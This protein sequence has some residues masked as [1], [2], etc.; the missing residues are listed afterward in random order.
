MKVTY[1]YES[2]RDH[3]LVYN[4]PPAHKSVVTVEKYMKWYSLYVV[5]PD[6]GVSKFFFP[7]DD[8][9]PRDHCPSPRAVLKACIANDFILHGESFEYIIGRYHDCEYLDVEYPEMIYG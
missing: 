9:S 6:G 1:E 7:S 8:D 4:G 5:R 2:D 3:V